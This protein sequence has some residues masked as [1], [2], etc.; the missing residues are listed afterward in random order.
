MH[1]FVHICCD[2]Q[3]R[4]TWPKWISLVRHFSLVCARYGCGPR[5]NANYSLVLTLQQNAIVA[6]RPFSF[7]TTACWC[8]WKPQ[9]FENRLQ[10]VIFWKPDLFSSCV[11]WLSVVA[12]N[13]KMITFDR[14]QR[15]LLKTQPSSAE[16]MQTWRHHGHFAHKRYVFQSNQCYI[17]NRMQV[18]SR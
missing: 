2:L 1:L 9:S 3:H 8:L 16:S 11:T 5:W 7:F 14:F 4:W 17:D 10:S 15:P 12:V 6:F 13:C 18:A